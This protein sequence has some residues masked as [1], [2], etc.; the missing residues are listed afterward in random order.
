MAKS[1]GR[2]FLTEGVLTRWGLKSAADENIP[3]MQLLTMIYHDVRHDD[4]VPPDALL[5]AARGALRVRALARPT[6]GWTSSSGASAVVRI[7]P[8]PPPPA[9]TTAS[10][11]YWAFH[12]DELL[13]AIPCGLHVMHDLLS[14]RVRFLMALGEQRFG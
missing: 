1:G 13:G 7:A 14:H 8:S 11:P 10:P 4:N 2:R 3:I 5:S 9:C 6:A 12:L